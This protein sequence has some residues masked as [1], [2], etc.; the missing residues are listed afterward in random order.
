MF[1]TLLTLTY[2]YKS[3]LLQYA[4]LPVWLIAVWWVYFNIT[5]NFSFPSH[6]IRSDRYSDG[7]P[8]SLSLIYV[9]T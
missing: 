9:M 1:D 2:I 4:L 3:V 8:Y 7:L 5:V 6:V